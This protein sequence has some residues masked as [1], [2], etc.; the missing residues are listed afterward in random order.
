MNIKINNIKALN[1]PSNVEIVFDDRQEIIKTE[2]GNIIEDL[3][4]IESGTI[5]IF[6]GLQYK[7]EDFKQLL[8]IFKNRNL[9]T[10]EDNNGDVWENVR[11]RINKYSYEP[12]FR[13]YINTDITI[14]MI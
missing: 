13:N 11:I 9:V 8:N 14:Y 2:G 7:Y 10:L 4:F 12:N 6:T 3:G 5:I 1:T